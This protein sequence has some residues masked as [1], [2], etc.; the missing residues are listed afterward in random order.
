MG[1]EPLI[2]YLSLPDLVLL[3]ARA[4]G[5]FPSQPLSIKPFGTL[6]ALG[7]YVGAYLAVVQG[8]RRGLSERALM[9]LILYV[10]VLSFV[11]G[12]VLDLVFYYPGQILEDP[13]SLLRLWDGLSSFGGFVGALLAGL[14][15]RA[16]HR[17]ALLPYA[18]ALGSTFPIGWSFGRLGCSFAH[19]HPGRSSDV[20]W[21]VRY[22]DGGR[23]DLG[24]LELAIT[25]PLAIFFVWCWRRPR[26][27]G[28]YIA[29]MSVYYAPLRFMMDFLRARP[30]DAPDYTGSV[31]PRY[32]GLTPAQ[33]ACVL[34][35]AFGI[36]LLVQI[37]RRGEEAYELP[38]VPDAFTSAS[39]SEAERPSGHAGTER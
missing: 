27:W 26:P 7:T 29:V 17:T 9:S 16:R 4:L 31:D 25:I 30:E 5:D 28:F 8:K 2:P 32:A 10:T 1:V 12:H 6:V 35:F 18:D 34:L 19:D 33:W 11:C 21:A 14:V 38:E 24:L 23:F 22:P 20:W 3:P 37:R 15:W 36:Y 39:N 13:L